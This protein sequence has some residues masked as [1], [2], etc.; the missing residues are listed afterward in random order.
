MHHLGKN[1]TN[2]ILL[3]IEET[4]E[5][6]GLGE[7]TKSYSA[8]PHLEPSSLESLPES[9]SDINIQFVERKPIILSRLGK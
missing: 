9:S 4:K 5:K 1:R 8:D 3:E 2:T 7:Y 6:K